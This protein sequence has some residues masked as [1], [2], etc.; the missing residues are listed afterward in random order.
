MTRSDASPDL[1]G[2]PS[3]LENA[4][5]HLQCVLVARRTR[6]NPEGVTWQ[7]YDVLELLRIR[8]AM[9]PSVLSASLGVSRQT[10]SKALRVLKDLDLVVQE[11]IG[12]DRRELTTSLTPTGWAFLAR[13]AQQRRDNAR[14]ATAALSAGER[15]MFVELCEKV[16][17]A[18]ESELEPVDS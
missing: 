11:A 10:T 3:E 17:A 14:I 2:E 15:A 16:V 18:F 7:Q 9:T 5:S 8:G 12:E 4:L 1:P 6:S 13:V